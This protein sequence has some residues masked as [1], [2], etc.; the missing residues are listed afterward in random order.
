MPQFSE[1]KYEISHNYQLFRSDIGQNFITEFPS[2]GSKVPIFMGIL[3]F[4]AKIL[5]FCAVGSPCHLPVD[6][7]SYLRSP[8]VP[9]SE[10][11]VRRDSAEHVRVGRMP[12]DLIHCILVSLQAELST[13]SLFFKTLYERSFIQRT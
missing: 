7:G 10:G 2:E 6:T 8:D 13:Q 11:F 4:L 3:A 5:R 1:I 12:S 9:E